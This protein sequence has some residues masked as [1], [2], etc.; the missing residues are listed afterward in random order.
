MS[1]EQQSSE[2]AMTKPEGF[3]WRK[4]MG[5]GVVS[6]LAGLVFVIGV[7]GFQ[8]FMLIIAAPVIVGFV[9]LAALK[10]RI[11]VVFLGIIGAALLF[12]NSRFM[13]PEFQRPASPT[14]F[15]PTVM[16]AVGL[17][18]LVVTAIPA[19]RQGKGPDVASKTAVYVGLVAV[20]AI[21]G[22]ALV[23]L[24]AAKATPDQPSEVGDINIVAKDNSFNRIAIDAPQGNIAVHVDNDGRTGHTFTLHNDDAM[25]H[26]EVDIFIPPGKGRRATFDAKPGNY[27][28]HCVFHKEMQGNITVT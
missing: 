5:W 27:H 20:I 25:D 2:T 4:L 1:E 19:F 10:G 12:L 18:L 11:G 17:L 15:I 7:E 16:L 22:G 21:L 6:M 8:F 24:M 26:S 9:L 14:D 23:T 3:G 13:I 28:F